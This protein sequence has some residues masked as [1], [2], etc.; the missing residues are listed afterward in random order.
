MPRLLLFF[1]LFGRFVNA[2][3]IFRMLDMILIPWYIV[4][5]AG[6]RQAVDFVASDSR[7]KA[8]GS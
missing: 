8:L 4:R 2:H 6:K 7:W 1:L 5:G 3:F